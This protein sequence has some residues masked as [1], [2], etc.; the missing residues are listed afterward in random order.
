M[1]LESAV[2]EK[3]SRLS[4][5]FRWTKSYVKHVG[6]A[7][8]DFAVPVALFFVFNM[9]LDVQ[10]TERFGLAWMHYTSIDNTQEREEKFPAYEPN[11]AAQRKRLAAASTTEY[12]AAAA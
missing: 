1:M 7:Y 11:S 6:A 12:V 10:D 5:F 4:S 9:A 2:S 8:L 3:E